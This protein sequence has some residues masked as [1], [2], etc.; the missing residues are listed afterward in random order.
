MHWLQKRTVQ[1][2]RHIGTDNLVD[3]GPG[4]GRA[5]DR[6][7]NCINMV[8][9]KLFDPAS[10]TAPRKNAFAYPLFASGDCFS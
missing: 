1:L 8:N 9:W 10:S 5:F 6:I 2:M 3:V 4:S 7:L